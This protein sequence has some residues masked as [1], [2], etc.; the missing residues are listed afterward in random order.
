[1]VG[2]FPDT[3]MIKLNGNSLQAVLDI[4]QILMARQLGKAH[5]QKLL[6]AIKGLHL[7]VYIV[8]GYTFVKLIPG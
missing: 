7:I 2:F 8:A 3:G 1:M 4:T 6:P 5:N